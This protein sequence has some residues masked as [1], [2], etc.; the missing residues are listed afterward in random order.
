MTTTS[1]YPTRPLTHKD[2]ELPQTD[3]NHRPWNHTGVLSHP[4]RLCRGCSEDMSSTD[5]VHSL[6][7]GPVVLQGRSPPPTVVLPYDVQSDRGGPRTSSDTV[8]PVR[9]TPPGTSEVGG[10]RYRNRR[11]SRTPLDSTPRSGSQGGPT[12]RPRPNRGATSLPFL[13]NDRNSRTRLCPEPHPPK[14]WSSFRGTT[15]PVV[16]DSVS[17]T[18][19]SGREVPTDSSS[20]RV[21]TGRNGVLVSG[22]SVRSDRCYG[23]RGLHDLLWHC[24]L[25]LGPC[26]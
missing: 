16:L 9:R 12:P 19:T 1:T 14:S 3:R 15:R 23:L 20:G 10:P 11:L 26:G 5:P 6:L 21:V 13:N 24:H 22:P 25:L 17:T 8:G 2:R 4:S 18:H 7:R